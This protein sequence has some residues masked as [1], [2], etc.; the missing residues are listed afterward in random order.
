MGLKS[1]TSAER[2]MQI[3]IHLNQLLSHLG[4]DVM[5]CGADMKNPDVHLINIVTS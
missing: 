5:L 1:I 3:I 4:F 2:A